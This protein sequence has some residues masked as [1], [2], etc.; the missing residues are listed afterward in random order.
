MLRGLI[1]YWRMSLAVMLAAA[2]AT[3][4]ITGALLVGGSVRASLRNMTLDRLGEVD[5]ALAANRFFR[6]DL[7]TDLSESPSRVVVPVILLRGAAVHSETGRRASQVNIAAVDDRFNALFDADL[8]LSR[9][10][11]QIFQTVIVNEALRRELGAQPGDQILLN[12]PRSSQIHRE[13]LMGNRDPADQVQTVRL[14]LT[15]VL[16]NEGVGRFSLSPKQSL[17]VNAFVSL[18]ALQ[19]ALEMEGRVNALLAGGSGLA[20]LES[21]L[22]SVLQLSDLGLKLAA[23]DGL[24]A[25]QSDEFVLS[26]PILEAAVTAAD[27]L[28]IP[29][30]PV[31][32]YLA[33]S[34][35]AR[36]RVVPYSTVAALDA[37]EGERPAGLELSAGGPSPRLEDDEILL[38]EWAAADLGARPG[39]EVKLTYY[40]VGARDQLRTESASFKLRGVT[41]MKG[42]GVSANL[43]PDFPGI[44]DA[45]D[46]SSWSPPFPVDLDQIRPRDED[47][48]DRYRAAPKAFVSGSAGRRLW[49]SRFGNATSLRLAVSDQEP[50]A[51]SRFERELLKVTRPE[52]A[53]FEFQPVKEQG[54]AAADGSTDFSALFISFSFFLVFSATLI[55]GLLFRLGVERR[56]REI[57]LLQ[58]VGFS[59]RAVLKRFLGEAAALAAIGG[60]MGLAGAVLYAWLLMAALRTWWVEAVGTTFLHLHVTSQSLIL[61]WAIAFFVV[62]LFTFAAVRKLF[63]V[64]KPQLLAGDVEA[65]PTVKP[66][67]RS[68]IA[69]LVCFALAGLLLAFSVW[70]SATAA[71][72]AAAA[73]FF[74]VG[75]ALL[76]G[77]LFF[78][79]AWC[80]RA[81]RRPMRV[82]PAL[83][84]V[85]M[86]AR[87]SARNP[88]RSVLSAALVASACFVIV[89]VGANRLQPRRGV[90][91]KSSGTGGF[92]LTARSEIPILQDLSSQDGRLELGFSEEESEDLEAVRVFPLRWLPGDDASCLNLYKPK[93]PSVLGVPPDFIER[94]G[95]TIDYEGPSRDNPWTLLEEEIEPGVIPAFGDHESVQWILQ[96]GLGDDVVI[97]DERG[98]PL[99]LRLAG[100]IDNSIFQSELLISE[101]NFLRR[102]PSR[103]GFSAFLIE[104][105]EERR[106]DL[107]AD[108]ERVL[109]PFGFDAALADEK[110]ASF[111]A[112][113]STYISTFQTLGGLGLLL[114]T[115][116]LA[117]VLIRN[118]IERRGELATLRAF[119]FRRSALAWMVVAENGFLLLLGVA[120]GTLSALAAV[121]PNL[122]SG[123]A[124]VPWLSL[125]A[126][127]G[128]VIL[129]GM[130]ASAAAV[131]LALRIPMLPAL[132]AQ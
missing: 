67:R 70:S 113:R 2:V 83:A 108:L 56:A 6:E 101:E 128:A 109:A 102:F 44:S 75:A 93:K 80:R 38:N 86:A 27:R 42:L 4:V 9:R 78:F 87:N 118:V 82:D 104:A 31:L 23:S 14:E 26:P 106:T 76:A 100:L 88:G 115:L 20:E 40:I 1:H 90:L 95:F 85:R 131:R 28:S 126:T 54:L 3:S 8:D 60:L 24:V 124:A 49:S 22:V 94:G 52:K 17:P 127:L 48:W 53:G 79:N 71:G 120:I 74:G 65:A 103:T 111:Q 12:L 5:F 77:G 64:A 36:G 72:T 35:E 39:D 132:K 13:S 97:E 29:A 7:A 110:L 105:P 34:I 19:R 112:V 66:G 98:N 84:L 116:G 81:G 73:G 58:S 68:R 11:G 10:Q 21:A 122:V 30:Q 119:G 61:G 46:V 117:V 89:A 125:A 18:K 62:L 130:L 33:N 96:L 45:E 47:Y 43:V 129:V 114:G 69:G 41:A 121:S 50:E 16:P 63:R 99:R 92:A 107:A 37:S 55:V 91:P 57:G 59:Q 32:T 15:R 123:G 25:L 51:I